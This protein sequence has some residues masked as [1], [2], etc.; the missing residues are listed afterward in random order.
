MLTW[1]ITGIKNLDLQLYKSHHSFFLYSPSQTRKLSIPII[2]VA[3][4]V[5]F[6]SSTIT[7]HLS[8]HLILSLFPPF[9]SSSSYLNHPQFL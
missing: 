7:G 3:L 5:L 4:L 9:F 8:L 1:V 2:H 6:P